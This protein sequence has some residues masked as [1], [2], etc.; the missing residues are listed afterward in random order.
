MDTGM[1][2]RVRAVI[3]RTG[4][5][6]KQLAAEI[7]LDEDK[8]SKSLNGKRRFSSFEVARMGEILGVNADW[9]ATGTSSHLVGMAARAIGVEAT[10]H[11]D[12]IDAVAAK[13]IDA[14]DV[15]VEFK[16][17]E[18]KLPALPDIRRTGFFVDEGQRMAAV[19]LKKI[20]RKT[21]LEKSTVDL[22][23]E[24]ETKFR[25]DIASTSQL[26]IGIDGLSFQDDQIRLVLLSATENWT[27]KRFTLAHELG[28]ILWGDAHNEVLTE[29]LNP[30]VNEDYREKRANQFAAAF[31][32]PEDSVREVSNDK[33]VTKKIFHAL[34]AKFRV[35]PSAMAARLKK[36]G[37]IDQD[38]Y[39]EFRSFRTRDSIA[40]VPSIKRAEVE[41][42]TIAQASW[43]PAHLVSDFLALYRQ[44]DISSK[45]L[46]DLTGQPESTWRELLNDS[47]RVL[48][49]V[50]DSEA[51]ED[52]E[53]SFLP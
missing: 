18:S 30:G 40:A 8:L 6:H 4:L 31:L 53:D 9:L 14:V 13:Y 47:F 27:R 32:M 15:L 22:L 20:D 5:S 28:H 7:P 46:V 25:V 16:K 49:A 12:A 23:A 37:V 21:L 52:S 51:S 19:A 48:A 2:D 26:P 11:T 36:L 41:E 44:G 24:L 39:F 43:A 50:G 29:K 33:P 34:V 17:R 38:R 42:M 35:S 1:A 45:P 10:D 3:A